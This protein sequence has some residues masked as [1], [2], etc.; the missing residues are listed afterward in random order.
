MVHTKKFMEK[1]FIHR[2]HSSTKNSSTAITDS[3]KIFELTNYIS[4]DSATDENT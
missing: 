2:H 1:K 3:K 4:F